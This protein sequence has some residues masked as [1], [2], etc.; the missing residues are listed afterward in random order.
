MS[1]SDYFKR[2][3]A[4][5]T[6]DVAGGAAIRKLARQG[7]SVDEIISKLD[8]P[9][10]RAKVGRTVY[11]EY[12]A[13]GKVYEKEPPQDGIITK[14]SYVKEY[15]ANGRSSMRQVEEKVAVE[16]REYVKCEFGKMKYQNT[17]EFHRKL[18]KMSPRDRSYIMDIQWPL[19]PVYHVKDEQIVRILD[20]LGLL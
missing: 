19:E 6:F 7:Y 13:C 3:L 9:V 11:S 4:N 14:I 16:N 18:D 15:G 2:A 8:Y 10:P 17:Q 20:V 12:V 1:E 5:F